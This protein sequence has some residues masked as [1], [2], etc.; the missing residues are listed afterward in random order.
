MVTKACHIIILFV[1]LIATTGMGISRHFCTDD[2]VSTALYTDTDSCCSDES[3]CH[4][5]S[6]FIQLDDSFSPTQCTQLPHSAE[7]DLLSFQFLPI[8]LLNT[9]DSKEVPYSERK[10]PTTTD[11]QTFLSLKQSYLL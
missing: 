11:C 6:E 7:I 1:L 9:D 4:N 3:C 2:L 10:P 5:E 8:I